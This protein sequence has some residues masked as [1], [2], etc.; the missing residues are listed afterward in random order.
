MTILLT[1]YEPFDDHESNPSQ[2]VAERLDGT[3]IAGQSVVGAVLP[4]E[5]DRVGPAFADL[6]VDHDPTV[7]LG[8]GLAP[9]RA[10][11]TVER[12]GINVADCVGVADNADAEPRHEAIVPEGPDAYFATIPVQAAV[13]DLLEAGIPARLSNTAGTHCCNNLLYA[14]RAHVADA[15]LDISVGFVHLPYSPAGAAR[16]GQEGETERGGAVPA[17]MAL[18]LQVA[19]VERVLA[20]AAEE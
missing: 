11:I 15:G 16:K 6:I 5:F 10:A 19:A 14:G 17:S 20:V 9:G 3:E 4:V 12:V 2:R 1:G 8:L 13:A 7:A 18:D